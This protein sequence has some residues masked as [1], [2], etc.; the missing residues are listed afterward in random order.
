MRSSTR[1]RT[2]V[3]SHGSLA[4]EERGT[5][6]IPI[7]LILGNSS[8]RGVFRHQTHGRLADNHRLITFDLPGHGESSNAPDPTRSY[9]TCPT[10]NASCATSTPAKPEP[11]GVLL[12]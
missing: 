3:A 2:I 7:L 9:G 1:Q 6:A 12:G 11:P 10:S 5:A 4:V 8:C